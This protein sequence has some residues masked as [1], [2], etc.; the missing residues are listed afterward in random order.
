VTEN[1]RG[2][3][4]PLFALMIVALFAIAGLAVD[5]SSAYSAR[6]GYRTASDAAALAG[7]QNLQT[8]GTRGVRPADRVNARQ[9]ALKSLISA[10]GAL[11]TGA[12]ACDPAVGQIDN[13][14]LKGTPLRV[15]VKTP[16]PT[17][18]RCDADHSVQVTVSNPTFQ[19]SFARVLGFDHWNVGTTS[20]AGLDFGGA[21]AVITLRPPNPDPTSDSN[22]SNITLNGSGTKLKVQEGDVGSNTSA[23]PNPGTIELDPNYVLWYYDTVAGWA[24]L[25]AGRHLS[26]VILDPNYPV[27]LATGSTPVGGVDTDPVR[28]AAALTAVNAAGYIPA[29]T[30]PWTLPDT[31]CYTPGVYSATLNSTNAKLTILEPGV[32]F[33]TQGLDLKG[34][35]VGGYEGG[36]QGVA[37]VIPQS[38]RTSDKGLKITGTPPI[39]AFN[40]G[41]A[42]DNRVGGREA[43]PAIF[44]GS[45]VQTNTTPA[46]IMSVIVPGVAA[47]PVVMPAPSCDQPKYLTL[48]Y[49]GAGG[50]TIVSVAGV[51]YAPS[52]N[53]KIAGSGDSKGYEGQIVAWTLTYSGNSEIDQ[54]YLG[55]PQV[56]ILRLDAACT[57]VP[58]ATPCNP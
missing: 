7:A 17:C 8:G 22:F 53:V 3:V 30:P 9:D 14:A 49:S 29:G 31:T 1:Q 48:D 15:S 40:R 47:C 54:H 55:G 27:P 50:V 21:Y 28:C 2:Q 11:G 44:N 57:L 41:D 20:V 25:P 46:L 12:G 19:L 5:V 6:Q 45:P 23:R 26:S 52:D 16:S 13:C 24:G 10:F 36:S 51:Q 43:T 38:T 18:V 37:I 35:I 34:E 56:G 32:Y 58:P 42:Y 33:L 39:V 4:L